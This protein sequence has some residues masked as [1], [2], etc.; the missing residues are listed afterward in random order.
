M[1]QVP[2]DADARR[3]GLELVD[4]FAGDEIDVV[5][6]QADMR[7]ADTV[8]SQVVELGLVDPKVLVNQLVLWL[9]H[10]K[11]KKKKG[12]TIDGTLED[13]PLESRGHRG[14][15]PCTYHRPGKR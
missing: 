9:L 15:P 3:D 4:D 7:V 6:L 10:F 2:C 8:A 14:R 13:I 12:L 5:G 11:K 1:L